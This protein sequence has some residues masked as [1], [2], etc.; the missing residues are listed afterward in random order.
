MAPLWLFATVFVPI[1]FLSGF[2]A[3]VIG[4]SGW[5]VI[6]PLLF[7]AFEFHIFDS[8]FISVILDGLNGLILSL[9]YAYKNK[10]NVRMSILFG[11]V[12]SMVV[13]IF[14]LF[15][16][17]PF[18]SKHASLLKGGVGFI[19]IAI[20]LVFLFKG[21]SGAWKW[22]K[23]KRASK[24][25]ESQKG[26]YSID[27]NGIHA[28]V[29]SIEDLEHQNW[30]KIIEEEPMYYQN[31]SI[32]YEKETI[33]PGQE[34][35]KDDL[36]VLNVDL[37]FVQ[38]YFYE[39]STKNQPHNHPHHTGD[40]NTID[41]KGN[42]LVLDKAKH[43]Y[44]KISL[45]KQIAAFIFT[46]LYCAFLGVLTGFSG[47]SGGVNYAIVFMLF[48][49]LDTPKAVGTANLIVFFTMSIFALGL[50][51]FHQSVIHLDV[52]WVT[53]L[54]CVASSSVGC[55]IGAIVALKVHSSI[56]NMIVASIL[57]LVGIYTTI[58][59]FIFKNR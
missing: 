8:L 33:Y 47:V 15:I 5:S 13:I 7:V 18:L 59:S 49:K 43:K 6:V 27:S 29:S 19:S 1:S 20:G 41:E 57:I 17:V 34:L 48:Y 3:A 42:T 21:L 54:I 40:T 14:I 36:S 26:S 50:L 22:F 51:C 9:L 46:V 30:K 58:Q 53:L 35:P 4:F 55:L 44:F 56:L 2:S 16:T 23:A 25:F 10:I 32:N 38:D 39:T 11:L 12:S 31:E 28:P 45:L 37:Q 24:V 52:I